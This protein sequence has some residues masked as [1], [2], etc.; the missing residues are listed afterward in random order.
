MEVQLIP[1]PQLAQEPVQA[2]LAHFAT[3]LPWLT[4]RYGLVQT[5]YRQEGTK[6]EKY[7]QL[8][9][10]DGAVFHLDIRPDETRKALCFFEREGQSRFAWD[11]GAEGIAGQWTHP[12]ALVV[13]CNLPLIDA[14]RGHDFSDELARDVV[15]ALLLAGVDLGSDEPQLEQRPERIFQR[16][17]WEVA[18]HQLLMY[19]FAAFRITFRATHP[20]IP[21]GCVPAPIPEPGDQ[22]MLVA[23]G[24]NGGLLPHLNFA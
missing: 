23:F 18:K 10:Q 8:Y 6:T 7:P 2:L 16:Y 19:P 21:A 9:P 11:P 1:T 3:A 20:D 22:M 14:E 24:V 17:G 15:R 13:W 12:L 5:G 4:H